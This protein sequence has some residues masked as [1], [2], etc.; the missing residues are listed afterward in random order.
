MS[1]EEL[2]TSDYLDAFGNLRI[3]YVVRSM[4]GQR[5]QGSFAY[6]AP[7][8]V[9][10]SLFDLELEEI[11]FAKVRESFEPESLLHAEVIP[12]PRI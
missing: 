10:M 4:T 6:A 7:R 11:V 2:T 3:F 12:I 8:G 9:P 1:P 5:V